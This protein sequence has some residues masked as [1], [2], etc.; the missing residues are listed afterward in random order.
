MSPDHVIAATAAPLAS[1]LVAGLAWW[2]RRLD[3]RVSATRDAAEAARD[4]AAPTGNGFADFVRRELG[5]IRADLREGRAESRET[6][7]DVRALAAR[8]DRHITQGDTP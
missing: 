1:V 7:A 4:L 8:L 2:L 6:R 5:G 3:S